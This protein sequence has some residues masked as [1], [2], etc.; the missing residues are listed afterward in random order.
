MLVKTNMTTPVQQ[1][2]PEFMAVTPE[3]FA[4]HAVRSIGLVNETTG[5]LSHQLQYAVMIKIIPAFIFD[6]MMDY[7]SEFI[8][9]KNNDTAEKSQSLKKDS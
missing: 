3:T 4:K 6:F 8:R 9:K 7:Q 5:C 1:D 2:F